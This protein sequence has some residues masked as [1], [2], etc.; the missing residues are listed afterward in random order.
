M[1]VKIIKLVWKKWAFLLSKSELLWAWRRNSITYQLFNRCSAD[2]NIS[3]RRFSTAIRTCQVIIILWYIS[4]SSSCVQFSSL[5]TALF[6]SAIS[7]QVESALIVEISAC[8]P[9]W[10]MCNIIIYVAT[11]PSSALG[12]GNQEVWVYDKQ[13]YVKCF[14][15][16]QGTFCHFMGMLIG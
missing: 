2:S 6:F 15:M 11:L 12:C 5:H 1:V 3:E 16:G 13:Q 14:E 10:A 8:H 4:I 7:L 9:S